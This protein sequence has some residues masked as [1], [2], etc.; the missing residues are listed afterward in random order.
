MERRRFAKVLGVDNVHPPTDRVFQPSGRGVYYRALRNVRVAD[1]HRPT[2]LPSFSAHVAGAAYAL[3]PSPYGL[4]AQ[5]DDTV[6]LNPGPGAQ[7]LASGL[8]MSRPVFFHTHNRRVYWTNGV[9]SAVYDGE[10]HPWL[11]PVPAEPRLVAV[12]GGAKA[13]TYLVAVSYIDSAGKEHARSEASSIVLGLGRDILVNYTAPTWA[14]RVRVWCSRPDGQTLYLAALVDAGV[15][16][17]IAGPTTA[18]VAPPV[19]LGPAPAYGAASV[20]ALLLT[21]DDQYVYPSEGIPHLYDLDRAEGY[22]GQIRTVLGLSG[23]F[24]VFTDNGAFWN[25]RAET[26]FHATQLDDL[27]Y[28]VGGKLVP[29]AAIPALDTHDP[30]ALLANRYGVIAATE[31]RLHRLSERHVHFSDPTRVTVT[32]DGHSIWLGVR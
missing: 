14:A 1:D 6:V 13:G 27:P 5:I 19:Q 15:F 4:L 8:T 28:P 11:T 9:E 18:V 20:G 16:P 30:V 3:H 24:W 23:G 12:P 22:V 32:Y 7:V 31:G 25:E 10:A 26:G 2:S 17:T 29:G 21:Y